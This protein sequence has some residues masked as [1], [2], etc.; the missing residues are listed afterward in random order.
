M[1]VLLRVVILN[2]GHHCALPPT[3]HTP[4]CIQRGMQHCS[5]TSLPLCHRCPHH[6][7]HHRRRSMRE[8]KS[9]KTLWRAG[10]F[11]KLK[12]FQAIKFY[13]TKDLPTACHSQAG[14]WVFGGRWAWHSNDNDIFPTTALQKQL[15]Y[16]PKLHI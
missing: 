4:Q 16:L 8:S 14:V 1:F 10:S 9:R 6:H 3:L 2:K 5:T 12:N 15:K 11:G 7:H 13:H